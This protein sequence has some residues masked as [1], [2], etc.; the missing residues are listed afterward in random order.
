M[1]FKI[2][3]AYVAVTPEDDGF[4]LG[5]RRIV[6]DAAA[7]VEA[8]VGLGVRDDAPGSLREDIDVALELVTDRLNADVGLGLRN[9]AVEELDADVKAGVELVEENNKVK[10]KVDP[11]AAKDA[12]QQGGSLIMAAIT[13]G[14]IFGPAAILTGFSTALAGVAVL[15][16][17]S[18]ADV[19]AEY[20]SLATDV[21]STLTDEI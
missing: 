17:K 20:K 4:E 14:A 5:L 11:Q 18:N 7:K 19:Q 9:D 2:A 16:A 21:S 15:V 10:V 13:A 12:G 8:K 3:S 1:A 6:E